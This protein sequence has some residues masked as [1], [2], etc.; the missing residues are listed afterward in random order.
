MFVSHDIQMTR[1]IEEQKRVGK[2]YRCVSK[3][4]I[5]A[6]VERKRRKLLRLKEKRKQ[7]NVRNIP[8]SQ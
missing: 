2:E 6:C 3:E 8:L 7:F 1:Y 5:K 4:A